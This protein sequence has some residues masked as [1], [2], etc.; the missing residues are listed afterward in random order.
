MKMCLVCEEDV[1][2]HSH[3]SLRC[4]LCGMS[5]EK[6]IRMAS[7][8]TFCSDRCLD[9]FDEIYN[10]ST[11]DERTNILAKEVVI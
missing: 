6:K 9:K 11:D 5:I 3:S 4:K 10:S 8:F 2:T 7:G 1:S